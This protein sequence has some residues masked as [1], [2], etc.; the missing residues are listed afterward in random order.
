VGGAAQALGSIVV[1]GYAPGTDGW[2]NT[3]DVG[4][5]WRSDDGRSWKLV[6]QAEFSDAS[7]FGVASDGRR[8]VAVGAHATGPVD[9]DGNPRLEGASWVSADGLAWEPT[10]GGPS[11][12]S[13]PIAYEFGRFYASGCVGPAEGPCNVYSSADGKAWHFEVAGGSTIW[14]MRSTSAGLVVV[15]GG[16]FRPGNRGFS[17]LLRDGRNWER[18]PDDP[19]LTNLGLMD[20]QEYDGE[21]WAVG[22]YDAYVPQFGVG[23][24]LMRG[25]GLSWQAV[26]YIGGLDV[27]APCLLPTDG[28]RPMALS[29]G[30]HGPVLLDGRGDLLKPV[31][32]PPSIAE[33]RAG[34][35]PV[36]GLDDGRWLAVGSTYADGVPAAWLSAGSEE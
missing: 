22:S 20:V 34:V 24:W 23:S 4:V 25:D 17:L 5:A 15:G 12:F 10:Y 2:G 31:A 36:I 6:T 30:E 14:A 18:S 16:G 21:L 13:G 28:T 3:G 27:A 1:V 26:S 29:A 7:L 9:N 8:F 35:C 19:I 33:T 32:E 11:F